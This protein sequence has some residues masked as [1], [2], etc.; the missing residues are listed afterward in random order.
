MDK[1]L[2]DKQVVNCTRMGVCILHAI[3]VSRGVCIPEN[4]VGVGHHK[5]KQRVH[6]KRVLID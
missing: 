2:S 5:Q 4:P 1:P 3:C 6:K